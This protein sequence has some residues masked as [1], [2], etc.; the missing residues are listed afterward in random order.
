MA[1]E[2][3]TELDTRPLYKKTFAISTKHAITQGNWSILGYSSGH[4]TSYTNTNK[5]WYRYDDCHVTK[6]TEGNENSLS[7]FYVHLKL[8]L[9]CLS[10]AKNWYY[11]QGSRHSYAPINVIKSRL[12]LIVRVNVVLNRTVVVDSDWRFD[13]LCGVIFRVKKKKGNMQHI[14]CNLS[15]IRIRWKDKLLSRNKTA[16]VLLRYL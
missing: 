10:L 9:S 1:W 12:S 8:S 5:V 3:E 4:Y 13:N 14:N 16:Y 15:K 2:C 6:V 11:P 7:S